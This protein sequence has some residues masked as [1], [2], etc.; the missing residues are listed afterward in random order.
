MSERETPPPH[1]GGGPGEMQVEDP[2][3]YN[4]RRRLESI[5]NFRSIVLEKLAL[6]EESKQ[7]NEPAR[8]ARDLHGAVKAFLVNIES[9]LKDRA[10]SEYYE[11]PLG[12]ITIFP[13]EE[14]EIQDLPSSSTYRLSEV[15]PI[16]DEHPEPFKQTIYGLVSDDKTGP[17]YIDYPATIREEWTVPVRVRHR[18]QQTLYGVGE[19]HMP[20]HVSEA[21]FRMGNE[22]LYDSGI[23]AR[24][25]D[26]RPFSDYS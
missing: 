8:V 2:G 25:D 24:L 15:E 9:L 13:P 5:N 16:G 23:D 22:F 20:V 3:D 11:K 19:T 12:E 10:D 18:G 6:M 4:Q 7:Q 14:F 17:G 1:P 21:A 26:G